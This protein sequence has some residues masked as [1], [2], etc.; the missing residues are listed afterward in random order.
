MNRRT[1][2][3]TMPRT[4]DR[5]PIVVRSFPASD[6][7]FADAT[8]AAIHEAKP[9]DPA[10]LRDVVEGRV[11]ASYPNARIHAQDELADLSMQEAVWYAYR[12]GRIRAADPGRER[13]YAAVATARRTVRDS[14]AAIDHARTVSRGA[15]F[16]DDSVHRHQAEQARP[17]DA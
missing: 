9:A 2:A 15:G 14:E 13:L 12:D 7:E 6:R 11:R 3:L 1:L 8:G 5:R 4:N 16:D 17:E 10:T